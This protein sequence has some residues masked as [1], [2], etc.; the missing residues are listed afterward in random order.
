MLCGNEEVWY[1]RKCWILFNKMSKMIKN[2]DE[3]DLVTI[4]SSLSTK[5]KDFIDMYW[6]SGLSNEAPSSHSAEYYA[7][8]LY[9]KYLLRK[10]I[11]ST[12]HINQLAYVQIVYMT[13]WEILI[14]Q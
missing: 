8:Q 12:N 1:N 13:Y 7:K 11:E 6:I 10:T 3:V 9:E 2:G 14:I 5:E 4:G